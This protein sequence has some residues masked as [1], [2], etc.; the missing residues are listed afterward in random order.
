MGDHRRRL[1]VPRKPNLEDLLK[2][3]KTNMSARKTQAASDTERG[4]NT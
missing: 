3:K 1:L 4:N 2:K